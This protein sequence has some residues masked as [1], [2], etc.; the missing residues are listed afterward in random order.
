MR[1]GCCRPRGAV[2]PMD[3]GS[4]LLACSRLHTRR[5]ALNTLD[6]MTLAR[7]TL[8]LVTVFYRSLITIL[9]TLGRGGGSVS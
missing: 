9:G 3:N 7:V 8:A 1:G 4:H 5:D 2:G 6:V